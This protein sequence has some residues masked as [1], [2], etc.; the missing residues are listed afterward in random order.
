MDVA[1]T[2]KEPGAAAGE[3]SGSHMGV[4]VLARGPQ[5]MFFGLAGDRTAASSHLVRSALFTAD[6]NVGQSVSSASDCDRHRPAHCV[7]YGRVLLSDGEQFIQLLV[8][9]VSFH[10][11]TD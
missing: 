3:L 6:E 4:Q 2:S 5:A 8:R 7:A 10:S 1:S 11:H 9:A